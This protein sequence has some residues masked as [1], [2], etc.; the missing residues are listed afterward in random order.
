[1]PAVRAALRAAHRGIRGGEPRPGSKGGQN[2]KGK[3]PLRKATGRFTMGRIVVEPSSVTRSK[4][5]PARWRISVN[6]QN[7]IAALIH[8]QLG[9]TL[10]RVFSKGVGK[11]IFDIHTNE[12]DSLLGQL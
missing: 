3:F 2:C 9:Q 6:A 1:M 10:T 12:G 11:D 7:A 8:D 4:R 5:L